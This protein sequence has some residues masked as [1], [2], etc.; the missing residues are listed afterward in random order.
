MNE[1]G[2]LA[3]ARPRQQQQRPLGGQSGLPLLR[4]EPGKIPGNGPPAGLAEAQF[5]FVVQH[6][7]TPIF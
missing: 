4:V 1:D 7:Y 2:G 6:M 5:L 3:A